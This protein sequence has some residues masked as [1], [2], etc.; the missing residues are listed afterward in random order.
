MHA[1]EESVA[2]GGAALLGVIS[3]EDRAFIADAIDVGV[4]PTIQAA[5]VD[6]WLHPAMSSP[7]IKNDVGLTGWRLRVAGKL[8]PNNA[9]PETSRLLSVD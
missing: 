5:M 1:G 2:P 7:M 6:A 4:S 3:H 9:M 8:S